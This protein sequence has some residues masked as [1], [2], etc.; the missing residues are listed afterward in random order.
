MRIAKLVLE[1]KVIAGDSKAAEDFEKDLN[2]IE[3]ISKGRTSIRIDTSMP[4]LH[5]E[6]FVNMITLDEASLK[7]KARN[8]PIGTLMVMVRN[9]KNYRK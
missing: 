8:S 4:F 3:E 9:P 5:V 2:C 6:S 1:K 7:K